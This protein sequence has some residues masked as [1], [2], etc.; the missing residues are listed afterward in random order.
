VRALWPDFDSSHMSVA[1]MRMLA[2]KFHGNTTIFHTNLDGSET[3]FKGSVEY[4]IGDVKLLNIHLGQDNKCP[5]C[6]APYEQYHLQLYAG[7][8][9]DAEFNKDCWLRSRYQIASLFAMAAADGEFIH[10]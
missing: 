4:V 1:Q 10:S 3:R 6:T 9:R 8:P 5:L 2:Q 7:E